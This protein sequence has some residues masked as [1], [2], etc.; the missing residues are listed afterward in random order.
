MYA[1]KTDRDII[2]RQIDK[3][4]SIKEPGIEIKEKQKKKRKRLKR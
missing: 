3:Y 1:H 4:I 2:N